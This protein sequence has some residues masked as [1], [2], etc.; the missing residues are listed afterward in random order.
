L[1]ANNL[2]GDAAWFFIAAGAFVI[3][4]AIFFPAAIDFVPGHWLKLFRASRLA[5]I[6]C[7]SVAVLW[8]LLV[9]QIIPASYKSEV[10]L[11]CVILIAVAAIHD[12]VLSSR[13]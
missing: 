12:I 2:S 13:R 4:L 7:A 8:G 6:L 3:Y 9:V 10:A 11:A 5:K 1:G